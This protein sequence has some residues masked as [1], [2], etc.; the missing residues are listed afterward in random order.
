MPTHSSA[1]VTPRSIASNTVAIVVPW[2][3]LF[4]LAVALVTLAQSGWLAE[5]GCNT[6]TLDTQQYTRDSKITIRW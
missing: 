6:D 3:L 4:E 5:A 1:A 2:S